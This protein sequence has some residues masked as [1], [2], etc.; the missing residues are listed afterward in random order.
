MKRLNT[1]KPNTADAG[2]TLLEILV[3]VF[4]VAILA[5]I[6]APGWFRYITNRRVQ[7]VQTE[8]RQ[9]M[10][11]AQT[12]ARTRRA[13]YTLEILEAEAIPTVRVTDSGGTVR[14][15]ELGNENVNPDTVQLTMNMVG[16]GT[17]F[18][19]D[20]Q[21]VVSEPFVVD[22]QPAGTGTGINANSSCVAVISLI[23]GLAS[24][25]GGECAD[26]RTEIGL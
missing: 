15:I 3:V 25:R 8:L 18:S 12:D 11:Q 21:G 7:A 2:F 23:G 22:V 5:A 26:F 1:P 6:A 10:E 19:F 14:D 16:G 4:I 17:V 24:G 9:V 13:E 20:Y